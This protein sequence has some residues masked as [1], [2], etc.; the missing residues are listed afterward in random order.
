M[1]RR[2]LVSSFTLFTTF[3][4]NKAQKRWNME[5]GI[6]NETKTARLIPC[7]DTV[8]CLPLLCG[9]KCKPVVC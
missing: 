1:K 6:G 7:H 9:L 2:I 8:M 4:M 3:P 5:Y